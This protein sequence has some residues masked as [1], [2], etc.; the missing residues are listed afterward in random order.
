MAIGRACPHSIF[1]HRD[2]RLTLGSF[3]LVAQRNGNGEARLEQKEDHQR[4][5]K[6]GAK[7]ALARC[8]LRIM[9]ERF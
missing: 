5:V 1:G 8:S 2:P 3:D 6:V 7:G 4:L 9:K